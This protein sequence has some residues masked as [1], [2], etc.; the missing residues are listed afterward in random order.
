L[1]QPARN[2]TDAC[3][4]RN[5]IIAGKRS[6]GRLPA[7]K[8]QPNDRGGKSSI[9]RNAATNSAR[10]KRAVGHVLQLDRESADPRRMQSTLELLQPLV[11]RH[12][13]I[14]DAN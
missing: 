1:L 12:H 11:G 5:L 14:D 2:R 3:R 13:V 6:G 7:L 4:P 10:E 9:A 8:H